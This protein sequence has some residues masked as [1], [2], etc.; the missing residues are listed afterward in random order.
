MKILYVASKF[1]YGHAERGWSF[2]HVNFYESLVRMGHDLV[3]FDFE[4]LDKELG[5]A[6]LNQRLTEM[7]AKERPE[8]MF[9]CLTGDQF[10]FATIKAITDAGVT[11]TFN[12]FCDD[13]FRFEKFSRRWAPAFHWVSTTAACALTWYR[14]IGYERV[15]KTQWAASPA[16]YRRLDLPFEYDVSFIGRVYRQRPAIIQRLRDQGVK[17]LVRGTGWPEGRATPEEMVAIFNQS[18]INLNF[19]DPPKYVNWFKRLLGRR[20]PPK[21]IKGRNFEIPGCGGFLLTDRAENLDD[22]YVP[23]KQIALF[24]GA[25]DLVEQIRYY[26]SHEQERAAIAQAGFERTLRD[27]TY[28]LRFNKLFQLM[29]LPSP[30]S[31]TSTAPQ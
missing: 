28:E 16:F 18:R 6:G 19:S 27:H 26:L 3:Y 31:A 23:G 17:V 14:H 30:P 21:Q 9:T 13:H 8:L 11:T 22:Y 15:I 25:D 10:E 7:A 29:R 4:T 24:D 2:E 20:Q 1:D 5:R 12:W